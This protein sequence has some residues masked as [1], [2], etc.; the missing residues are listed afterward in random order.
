M[1]T[2][3]DLVALLRSGDERA[4]GMFTVESVLEQRGYLVTWRTADA[5]AHGAV[6]VWVENT[7]RRWIVRAIAALDLA[8]AFQLAFGTVDRKHEVTIY[9]LAGRRMIDDGIATA[10]KKLAFSLEPPKGS[11]VRAS[12]AAELAP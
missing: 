9:D 6:K 1:S 8:D 12:R 5:D 7:R 10:P 3:E 11:P 4:R 2:L